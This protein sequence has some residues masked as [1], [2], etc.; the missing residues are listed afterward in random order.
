MALINLGSFNTQCSPTLFLSVKQGTIKKKLLNARCNAQMPNSTALLEEGRDS[1]RK[2]IIVVGAG[3]AGL[4]AA[5]HLTKQGFDVVLLEAGEQ[6]GGL[7]SGWKNAAGRSVEVGIHGFWYPYRNIFSLT[8]ELGIHP[9]TKWT[10]SA[11]YSPNGLEAE[12]PVFQDLPRLPS[13]LG[14]LIYPEFKTITLQDRLSSLLLMYPVIDFDNTDSAW[15]KYDQ[16][17][18]REL[19]KQFGCPRKVYE[20]SFNPMLQVGLFAPGELCS[21]AATLG[22]F[23]YFIVAHQQDFDVVWCRGTVGEKIFKPW[24]EFMKTKGCRF[25]PNKRVTDFVI[26]ENSGSISAVI[27]GSELFSADA[28]V[29]AVGITALKRI[30]HNSLV[31]K[32]RDEFLDVLNLGAIDVLAVRLWLDRKVTIPKPSNAC[33]G[34]DD[35]TGWTFFDLNALHDEYKDEPGTV[36][37]ADFYHANQI[38]PLD[39]EQIVHKVKGYL[40]KCIKEFEDANVIDQAVVRCPQSVTHFFP[41]SYRYMMRGNTSFPNLFMAGDWIINRHGSWSQEKAYVTGIEAANRVVD[42]LQEGQFSKI[43][44]VEDDEPHIQQLRRINRLFKEIQ[45]QLPFS[46]YLL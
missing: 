44:P 11:Q 36:V 12:S 41:G 8:E 46:D 43:I 15:K 26:N 6:P 9:F 35:S 19:F 24:I 31:L 5:H 30:I 45:M 18:A 21:A 23:Y 16:L 14:T 22:M 37:E 2:K 28:V 25:L 20:D 32:K 42:Y 7:V 4:G 29:L 3:W 40:S 39:N 33:F 38:L 13:P 1:N 17:T 34:F 10:R 27:C